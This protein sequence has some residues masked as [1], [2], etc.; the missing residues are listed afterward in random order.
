MNSSTDRVGLVSYAGYT[1]GTETRVDSVLIKD[2]YAPV[3]TAINGLSANGATETRVALKTAID[4]MAAQNNTNKRAIRAIIL[5]TD[6]NWNWQGTPMGHGTGW[7]SNSTGGYSF[8]TSALEPNNYLWYEGLGGNLT[9]Y[10][11][12]GHGAYDYWICIDGETTNQNMTNYAKSKGIRLYTISFAGT[13]DSDAVAAMT[14]MAD[15]TGGFYQNAPDAATLTQVYQKIAGQLKE[16]AGINT[17]IDINLD[18]I[19]INSTPFSGGDVFNYI[20]YSYETKKWLTNDSMISGYPKFT[21]NTNDWT[22]ANDYTLKFNAGTIKLK[23]MWQVVYTLKVL[24]EGNINVFGDNSLIRF[25]DGATLTLPDTYITAAYNLTTP[26]LGNPNLE[27]SDL[28]ET[29]RSDMIREWTWKRNYTGNQTMT[30]KYYISLDN[31]QRWIQIGDAATQ[32]KGA[33]V[34]NFVLDLTK[35]PGAV[36]A[37]DTIIFRVVAS[38]IDVGSPVRIQQRVQW[39]HKPDKIYI[40]LE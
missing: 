15:S 11:K 30:E 8:S 36:D 21:D 26:A 16:D 6:G 4:T 32:E 10:V 12:T 29:V 9:H 40:K 20:K 35:I 19:V 5:M 22:S 18:N 25:N 1:A 27:L 23:Q 37:Q 3:T 2:N 34:G 33:S 28:Q 17:N 14:T 39:N 38:A 7:T 13:L 31:G 24:K